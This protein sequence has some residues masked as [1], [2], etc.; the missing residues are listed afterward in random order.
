MVVCRRL[1][2]VDEGNYRTSSTPKLV[3]VSFPHT[4]PDGAN[5]PCRAICLSGSWWGYNYIASSRLSGRCSLRDGDN[6]LVVGA[7]TTSP[8]RGLVGGVA[9]TGDL[10][11]PSRRG[12]YIASS[13]LG[14]TGL[15]FQDLLAEP[16]FKFAGPFTFVGEGVAE[17]P[18]MS[19]DGVNVHTGGDFIGDEC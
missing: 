10:N 12:N 17:T 5:L 19:A 16:F 9:L 6:R 3:C 15:F 18:A 7:I 4:S 11:V 8:L 1:G 2:R 13:R 14:G